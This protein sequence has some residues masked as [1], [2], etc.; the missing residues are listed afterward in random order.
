MPAGPAMEGRARGWM[1]P[2]GAQGWASPRKKKQP[3]GME[4][5]GPQRAGRGGFA[6][7]PRPLNQGGM[8][9]RKQAT[10]ADAAAARPPA[11]WGLKDC[12]TVVQ[13]NAWARPVKWT[14]GHFSAFFRPQNVGFC[15]R[16]PGYRVEACPTSCGLR[17]HW[18]SSAQQRRR[19]CVGDRVVPSFT[20]PAWPRTRARTRPRRELRCSVCTF[21]ARMEVPHV[22]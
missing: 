3:G 1:P 4:A 13:Q 11:R 21:G 8:P 19:A 5:G 12:Y 17:V 16:P 14:S 20:L 2:A 22:G 18:C 10:G 6:A 7:V 9:P 15:P